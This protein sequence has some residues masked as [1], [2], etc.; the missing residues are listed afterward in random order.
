MFTCMYTSTQGC[1]HT[2]THKQTGEI[3]AKKKVNRSLLLYL[4]TC[5]QGAEGGGERDLTIRRNVDADTVE[6]D[7]ERL[8]GGPGVQG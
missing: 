6:R 7:K 3:E 8:K 4:I 2:H 1:V 5:G